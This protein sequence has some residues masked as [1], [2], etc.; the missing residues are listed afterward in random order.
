MRWMYTHLQTPGLHSPEWLWLNLMRL[1]GSVLILIGLPALYASRTKQ[2]GRLG[3]VGLILTFCAILLT[4]MFGVA[5]NFV[6]IGFLNMDAQSLVVGQGTPALVWL[7]IV[8]SVI[9]I[10]VSSLLGLALM[11]A[12]ERFVE[13]ADV[14]L[15]LAFIIAGL[16]SVVHLVPA[17]GSF[18]ALDTVGSFVA[19]VAF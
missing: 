13:G 5:L 18:W 14:A 3:L 7:F 17:T 9:F 15:G 6:G 19:V 8:D 16:S 10:V 1:L 12:G 2:V 4:G 11:R